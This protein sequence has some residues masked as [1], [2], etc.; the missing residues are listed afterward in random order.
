MTERTVGRGIRERATS[1]RGTGSAARAALWGVCLL[2]LLLLPASLALG[3]AKM[4]L[5]AVGAELCYQCHPDLKQKFT[6][7][8]H[9]HTPVKEG[10]CAGC[11]NPH[12][13]MYKHLLTRV[14][15]ELCFLCHKDKKREFNQSNK[16]TPVA[17]GQCISCHDPHASSNK[18][19]LVRTGSELC[20][21]CHEGMKDYL[22]KDVVHVPFKEGMCDSC[23]DP[24]ASSQRA[25][26]VAAEK[27]LCKGCHDTASA[28]FKGIHG[29]S[30]VGG[31][32]FCHNPHGSDQ[33]GMFPKFVHAPFAGGG[34][35][36]CHKS[37]AENPKELVKAGS[38]LCFSCHAD[39][40]A[41]FQK[42]QTHAPVKEGECTSCHA[43]HGSE[44]KF[45]LVAK[46]NALCLKC[47][48]E[49]EEDAKEKKYRHPL[50][51]SPDFRCAMCH[52]PHAS[53]EGKLFVLSSIKLC[54]K[55]H[56]TQGTFTHPVGEGITDPRDKSTVTCV[57]CH[58][59]HG[60][61]NS[62]LLRYDKNRELCIQ[63][64]KK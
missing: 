38:E 3:A 9:I 31:C 62:E 27:D 37:I 59:T 29:Q 33:K 19:Q 17:K 57:T 56:P 54:E 46:E 20:L 23:H 53:D 60:T 4:K 41:K 34:C 47:H 44:E 43:P 11:H 24:H 36:G 21:G 5:R 10:K 13:A 7:Q 14:G 2:A 22:K 52:S 64:H 58:D 61:A 18:S 40:K 26:L 1:G 45:F 30:A 12:T 15:A 55:C 42:S 25:Q 51:E 16:H 6:A 50:D 35:A 32:Y 8:P 28:E 49:V 39:Q 48:I 63:C